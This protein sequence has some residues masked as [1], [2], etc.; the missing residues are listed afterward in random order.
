ML[1]RILRIIQLDTKVFREIAADANAT[2]E[3][4]I[5]VVVVSVLSAIGSGIASRS[6]FFGSFLWELIAGV[7]LG[8]V[9]WAVIS[10]FVGT[11]LFNGKST[12]EEML[13]VLGYARAPALLG[14]FSFIPCVGWIA[15]LAGAVLSLIA[16]VIAIREAMEFDTGK[17]IITVL[18]GWVVYLI[19]AALLAPIL[20]VGYMMVR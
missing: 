5:V 20:G 4:A 11:T 8:W 13:R 17:A 14:F 6:S 18:I 12:I 15:A 16:G 2:V 1:Q 9:L 3:A 19:L 10:Y 7:L